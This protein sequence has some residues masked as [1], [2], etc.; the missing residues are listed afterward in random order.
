MPKNIPKS[1]AKMSHTD[2]K[3]WLQHELQE[4]EAYAA[5]LRKELSSLIRSSTSSSL[6]FTTDDRPDLSAMKAAS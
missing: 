5:L 4:A 3:K 6:R 2:R 1:V